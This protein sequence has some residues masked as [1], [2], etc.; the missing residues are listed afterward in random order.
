[1]VF[2]ARFPGFPGVPF[3]QP[4]TKFLCAAALELSW[5]AALFPSLPEI[6]FFMRR[7]LIG[8]MRSLFFLPCESFALDFQGV[9]PPSL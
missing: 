2:P 7:R 5:P 8:F 9:R 3:R 4:C 1:M 6:A